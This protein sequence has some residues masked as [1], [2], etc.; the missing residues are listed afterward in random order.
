MLALAAT[1]LVLADG[2]Q[3]PPQPRLPGVDELRALVQRTLDEARTADGDARLRAWVAQRGT[4]LV[5]CGAGA[6]KTDASLLLP[7]GALS[8]SFTA[9]LALKLADEGKLSLERPLKEVLPD[10]QPPLDSANLADALGGLLCV[11]RSDELA[12]KSAKCADYG[13]WIG[14]FRASAAPRSAHDADDAS[15]ALV[16]RACELA[17]GGGHADLVREHLLAPLDVVDVLPSPRRA[18]S[19]AVELPGAAKAHGDADESSSVEFDASPQALAAWMKSLLERKL[20]SDPA[21]RRYMTPGTLLDGN[22]SHCGYGI[23]QS[24]VAGLKRYR[25]ESRRGARQLDLSYWSLA[26]MTVVVEADGL[27]S[28]LE[29]LSRRISLRAQQVEQPALAP[30]PYERAA[31]ERLAGG[32]LAGGRRFALRAEAYV[33]VLVERGG[34][35]RLVPLAGGAFGCASDPEARWTAGA[36]PADAPAQ[37][38]ELAKG[39]G[40]SVARRAP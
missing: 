15:W 11:P 39:G 23:A 36:G 37:T 32:W 28:P 22:P 30:V 33:L 9:V 26:D 6:D 29:E 2:P 20:L 10:I 12:L 16:A 7:L 40:R 8:H 5:G 25:M 3:K 24:K 17:G 35:T 21:T 13:E 14:L 4:V 34:E 38:L 27:D 19:G 31:A 1:L 18:D